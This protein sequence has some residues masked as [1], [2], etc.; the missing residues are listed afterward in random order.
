MQGEQ[1]VDLGRIKTDKDNQN[2]LSF[3]NFSKKIKRKPHEC[4]CC[5]LHYIM[6]PVPKL[7]RQE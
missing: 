3:G 5:G 6:F 1:V 4:T 7:N 2:D